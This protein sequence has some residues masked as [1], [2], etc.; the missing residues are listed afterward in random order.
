M[1]Y[2]P[3]SQKFILLFD[4]VWSGADVDVRYSIIHKTFGDVYGLPFIAFTSWV[5]RSGDISFITDDNLP[6]ACG[7]MD[8]LVVTY[9][10]WTNNRIYAADLRGNNHLSNPI[11]S[12]DPVS[13][14]YIVQAFASNVDPFWRPTISS[15]ASRAEMFVA[16]NAHPTSPSDY[17][18]YGRLIKSPAQTFIPALFR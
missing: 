17:N 1:A 15:G 12:V 10:D 4:H 7:T 3:C 14:H 2:D 5:E 6:A 9:T 18:A 11:Y 13:R 16:F 8:K